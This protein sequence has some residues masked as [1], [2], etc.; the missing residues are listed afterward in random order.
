LNSFSKS[1]L[2]EHREKPLVFLV[3]AWRAWIWPKTF[4]VFLSNLILQISG[5]KIMEKYLKKV[6][7]NCLERRF[8]S[9]QG[10]LSV[11]Q[12]K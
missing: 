9:F 6:I 3:D 10:K 8:I 11:Y 2:K 4:L 5:G 7:D 1:A 12:I